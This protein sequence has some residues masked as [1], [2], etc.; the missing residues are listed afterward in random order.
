MKQP[1]MLAA[2]LLSSLGQSQGN[3]EI[4]AK[5]I[6]LGKSGN[7]TRAHLEYLCEQIGHRL[8]GSSNLQRACDWTAAKFKEFGCQNVH[9]EQWGEIPVGFDR[10]SRHTG[11]MVSPKPRNFEF[12]TR[13]W[14]AG[15]GGLRSGGVFEEPTTVEALAKAAPKGK[16]MMMLP[17]QGDGLPTKEVRDAVLAGARAAG[18]LGTV[19]ASRNELVIT[20]GSWENLDFANLPTNVDI[21]VRK[22]D[23]EAVTEAMKEGAKPVLEFNLDQKFVKGPIPVYNV[24][25]EIPGASKPDEVVIVSGHLDSWDGPGSQGTC[26]NGT[27][28]MV[29]LEAARLL[30]AAGA[31][32]ERTIRFI[33][34]TGEEQGLWG[35]RKYVEAHTAELPKIS[36]VIVDDGG[37]NYCGGLVGIESMK[38][39]LEQAIAPLA[40][41]F[42]DLPMTIRAQEKMPQGGGS[43][44]ASFNRAGVPG[45]FWNETGVADYTYIHH[46]QHD[47]LEGA[48]NRYL[49]QSSVASAVTAYNLA[50]APTMLPRQGG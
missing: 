37:T 40:E 1:L 33:L 34:W 32:P 3:P 10:G 29:A 11:R 7:Q 36:A 6:E 13:S 19:A 2:L 30:M 50:C 39:M 25:A 8:T 22:S 49:V 42:P 43:D 23:F 44:H 31:K 24:I 14:T 9:L 21:T 38:P 48:I 45:F 5:V 18:I 12:T 15:T 4:V 46:T 17:R 16:W 26:D 20:S 35:S 27:G 41:A 47:K 28:T